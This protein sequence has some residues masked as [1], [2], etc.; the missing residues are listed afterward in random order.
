MVPGSVP[1]VPLLSNISRAMQFFISL[2]LMQ[3]ILTDSVK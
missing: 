1:P 3:D 2:F